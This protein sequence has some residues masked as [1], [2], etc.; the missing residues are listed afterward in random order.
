MQQMPTVDQVENP[1]QY[2]DELFV[3]YVLTE[4]YKIHIRVNT[5]LGC[6]LQNDSR[7]PAYSLP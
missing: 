3:L 1:A 7:F 6:G 2:H 4:I 5:M